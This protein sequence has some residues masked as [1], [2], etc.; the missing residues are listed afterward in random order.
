MNALSG[1]A[2][3][4]LFCEI[5]N[6]ITHVRSSILCYA[7]YIHMDRDILFVFLVYAAEG[8]DLTRLPR[9]ASR[10]LLYTCTTLHACPHCSASTLV[11]I[12]LTAKTL[13]VAVLRS[14]FMLSSFQS[15]TLYWAL[16][17]EACAKIAS[18]ALLRSLAS[19]CLPFCSSS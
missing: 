4:G 16:P 14:P 7:S 6:I 2:A 10:L 19:P 11:R 12:S 18:L 13:P 17:W 1:A 3:E 8:K 15:P 9:R 5:R